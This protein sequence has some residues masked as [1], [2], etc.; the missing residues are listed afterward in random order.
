[1]TTL[2]LTPADAPPTEVTLSDA[3]LEKLLDET[4]A[5]FVDGQL[6]EKS[7]G[8]ESEGIGSE[9]HILLGAFVRAAGLGR[10]FGAATPYRCFPN[11][12]RQI[13]RPDVSFVAVMRLPAG[14][15]PR[16]NFT[17]APDLAVEVV[18]PTD[19]GEYLEQK[20]ADYRSAGVRLIWVVYP[21]T[22]TV[23]IRRLDLT[24]AELDDTGALDGEDV[25]PGFQCRVAE[26]FV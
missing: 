20:V 3:E 2:L 13:R 16:G 24:C 1:M 23:L 19:A 4:N 9:L 7:M 5:E 14:R 26:L 21:A 22:R 11:D 18:S 17:F 8:A 25:V 10:V 15:L 6:K 12:P